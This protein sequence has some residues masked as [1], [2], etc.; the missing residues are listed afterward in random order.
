MMRTG[1]FDEFP[2]LPIEPPHFSVYIDGYNLYYAINHPRPVDLLRLGWCNYQRL[3]E[4]LVERSFACQ[5]EKPPVTVKY[6]TAEVNQ[7]TLRPHKGEINRQ[8][9]WL[10]ALS[11]EAPKLEI[12]RGIWSQRDERKEKMTDVKI[13]LEIVDRRPDGIVLVSDDLDFQPVV[14]H[15]ADS[16]V[17]IAVFTPEDHRLNNVAPGKDKSLVQFAYLTQDLMLQCHLKSDFLPYLRLKVEANPDFRECLLYEERQ[18]RP[19][20]R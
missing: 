13:A 6:F 20:R 11:L 15:V 12:K 14:E 1:P 7:Q 18:Q 8:K 9:M 10:E 5:V 17:P 4:L 16:G 19:T 3:G 2:R